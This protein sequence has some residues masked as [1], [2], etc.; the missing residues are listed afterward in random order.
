MRIYFILCCSYEER[1]RSLETV[2]TKHKH[3]T[4]YEEFIS[5][6]YS[7][8]LKSSPFYQNYAMSSSSS[9]AG[10]DSGNSSTLAAALLDSHS[11]SH[12]NMQRSDHKF[13]GM[14]YF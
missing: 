13:R 12:K 5:K 1:A 2:V 9:G 7:P 6:V 3:S 4:T 14:Y 11:Q 10:D 8:V